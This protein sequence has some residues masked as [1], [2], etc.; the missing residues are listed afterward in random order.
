MSYFSLL[1]LNCVPENPVPDKSELERVIKRCQ[2][3]IRTSLFTRVGCYRSIWQNT[4]VSWRAKGPLVPGLKK[5]ATGHLAPFFK[6]HTNS[7]LFLAR[8]IRSACAVLRGGRTP[9]KNASSGR[10]FCILR[11]ENA[12]RFD[13]QWTIGSRLERF[14]KMTS[15]QRYLHGL[16]VQNCHFYFSPL[17]H[18]LLWSHSTHASPWL[19]ASRILAKWLPNNDAE[20]F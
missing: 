5:L 6:F 19:A 16:N 1:I 12:D 15:H 11:L 10:K 14:V 18:L 17:P 20:G 9:K 4:W 13:L 3:S 2:T 8:S 7:A